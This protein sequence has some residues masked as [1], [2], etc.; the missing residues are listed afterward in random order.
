MKTFM[1]TA[2]AAAMASSVAVAEVSVPNTFTQGENAVAEEVNGNFSALVAAINDNAEAISQL[3]SDLSTL[4]VAGKTY[5]VYQ[6]GTE[7]AR[8]SVNGEQ[9]GISTEQFSFTLLEG[10]GVSVNGTETSGEVNFDTEQQEFVLDVMSES[11]SS[12]EGLMW[13]VNGNVL[14]IEDSLDPEGGAQF[15]IA[16]GARTLVDMGTFTNN[17]SYFEAEL[18]LGVQVLPQ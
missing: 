1:M 17:S 16:P 9:T 18:L 8:D 10:G 2:L 15:I 14:T 5:Q 11:F 7:I 13:S 6:Y 4:S 3:Q 12:S